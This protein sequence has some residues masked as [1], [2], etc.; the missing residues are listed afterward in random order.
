MSV[1]AEMVDQQREE[2]Q[3][4][5]HTHTPTRGLQVNKKTF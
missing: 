4:E 1:C 5:T 3:D 2:V